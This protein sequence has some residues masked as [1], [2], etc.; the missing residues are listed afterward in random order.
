MRLVGAAV[1][2]SMVS[3]SVFAGTWVR[4]TSHK[5]TGA[6]LSLLLTDGTVIVHKPETTEWWKLTPDNTGSY[7]NGTWT[8]I[9]SLPG[10]YSPLYYASAV[11]GNG[12]VFV[13]GGEYENSG[14]TPVWSNRG[15]LYDPL[16]NKWTTLAA[17]S[18]WGNIGDAQCVVLPNGQLILANP[19]DTRMASLNPSNLTWTPL[20][21]AGKGDAFDEEGWTLLPDGTVLTCD[22]PNAPACEKYVPIQDRWFSAG[23][24]PFSLEDPSSEEMGPMVLM[25]NGK[26]FATGAT[27]TAHTAI[28]T[29]GLVSTDPGTWVDGPQFDTSFGIKDG[30]ACLLPNGHVLVSPSP[31]FS[32]PVQFY[33]FDGSQFIPEPATP[34]S[35][36]NPSFVGC[37]LVLPTGQ[38]MYTDHSADVEIYTPSGTSSS[39]WRP[40]ITSAPATAAPGSTFTLYGK[41]L[42]G[43]S[44]FNAYGDDTTNAE[45]YPLVRIKNNS[46]GHVRYCRTH[47]H[48]TMG[49]ATGGAV[50][51]TKVTVPGNIEKGPSTITVVVGGIPSLSKAIT[52]GSGLAVAPSAVAVLQGTH[53]S[54]TLANIVNGT[55]SGYK[56][57]SA[58]QTNDDY[59]ELTQ[60]TFAMPAGPTSFSEATFIARM[61]GVGIGSD[62]GQIFIW[63][64]KKSRWDLF[65]SQPLPESG[66]VKEFDL[67]LSTKL[68]D[69]MDGS[70]TVKVGC[71]VISALGNNG[72]KYGSFV[73]AVNLSKISYSLN[74]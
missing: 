17:P 60:L 50:V 3:T 47:D 36:G 5:V 49:V 56:V 12:K 73:G 20:A 66:T 38:V 34:N 46:T 62:T 19:F 23:S 55:G 25:Y 33:E 28:Y 67:D 41:Q 2:L 58:H 21:G 31:G 29:P 61:S 65:Q 35:P 71:R 7:V 45:N 72:R 13:M 8:Q 43:L 64:T 37:M 40:T 44:Q 22:S 63:N 14:G 59:S 15:A 39:A 6:S 74:G 53:K 48:S 68:A 26:V 54:G 4:T 42:N 30:P 52:I 18:G 57:L 1:F 51:S 24:T 32:P 11:L 10:T 9:A 27:A 69:Y 16:T 70:H